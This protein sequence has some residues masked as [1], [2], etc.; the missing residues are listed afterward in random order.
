[1]RFTGSRDPLPPAQIGDQVLPA[2]RRDHDQDLLVGRV[3]LAR[4]TAN[5]A[6]MLFGGVCF[7][8]LMLVPFTVTTACNG[9]PLLYF[10]VHHRSVHLDN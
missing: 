10:P 8:G 3:H 2:E 4:L 6:D 5:L 1:V 9:S 7:I